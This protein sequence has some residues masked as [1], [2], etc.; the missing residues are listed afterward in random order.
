MRDAQFSS[1]A[2]GTREYKEISIDGRIQFDL[3]VALQVCVGIWRNALLLGLLLPS[4]K[5]VTVAPVDLRAC[6]W[7]II[8]LRMTR[9]G[10]QGKN[11]RTEGARCASTQKGELRCSVS[12][13]V[14]RTP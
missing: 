13:N 8:Q 11:V 2:Y 6:K 3:L 12:C 14:M 9:A 5:D 10:S 4:G 1:K 7:Q